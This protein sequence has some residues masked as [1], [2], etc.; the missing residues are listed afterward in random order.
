MGTIAFLLDI[1]NEG[2]YHLRWMFVEKTMDFNPGLGW[3]LLVSFSIGYVF[4]SSSLCVFF[5]PSAIGSG[6]AEAMG[7][8]NGVYYPDYIGIKVFLVKFFGLTLAVA[9]GICGGKEGPLVH[10]GSILGYA[11]P[12]LDKI[13]CKQCKMGNIFKYF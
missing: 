12:Y 6:V 4:I 5:A 8:L 2:L 10:M 11:T 3:C 13:F 1:L 9:G 7:I